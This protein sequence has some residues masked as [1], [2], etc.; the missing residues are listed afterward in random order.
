VPYPVGGVVDVGGRALVQA[1]DRDV[2]LVVVQGG[3]QAHQRAQRV[4]HHATP[5]PGVQP[6]VER[7]NLDDAVGQ[8]AQGHRQRRDLGAPV[9]R[10]GDHDHVGGQQ[11]PVRGE[12]GT[13]GR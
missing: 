1:R 4:G 11:V 6:V 13:E 9:V 5:H 3:Q 7:R 12:Q 8:P 10:V 2:A